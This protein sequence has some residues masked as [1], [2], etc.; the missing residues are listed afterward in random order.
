MARGFKPADMAKYEGLWIGYAVLQ[1]KNRLT[2][3]AAFENAKY[4]AYAVR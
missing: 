1:R 4:V 3:P 2:Q